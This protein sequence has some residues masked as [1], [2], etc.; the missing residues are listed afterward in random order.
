MEWKYTNYD[1]SVQKFSFREP[2]ELEHWISGRDWNHH[3]LDTYVEYIGLYY[4]MVRRNGK[5]SYL[6]KRLHRE[7]TWYLKQIVK[8]EQSWPDKMT[9]DDHESFDLV[10][11][12]IL[13]N[14]LE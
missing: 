7:G 13:E 8:H 14:P 6:L 1:G 2:E 10:A 3:F 4:R 5:C 12:W 11:T 9:L